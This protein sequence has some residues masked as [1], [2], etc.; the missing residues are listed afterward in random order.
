MIRVLILVGISLVCLS[1][2]NESNE[3]IPISVVS[4]EI[5]NELTVSEKIA[6]AHGFANWTDVNKIEFR[7]NVERDGNTSGRSWTW[8]P[9]T[10][11][12]TLVTDQDTLSF[13]RKSVDSL[14]LNADRGF[15]N[16]KFWLFIPFQLVWDDGTTL[17]DPIKTEAPISKKIMNKITLSYNN[18]GG[19]TPGDAYD[20]FYDDDYL[21]K[22]WVFRKGNSDEPSLTTTFENYQDYNGIILA[23]DH[24]KAEGD[25]NLFFSNIKIN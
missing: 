10:D 12:V 15:I 14:S 24:R 6:Q 20:I 5:T 17:S 3:R 22:E 1:C 19:Y 8:N 18:E 11:H 4:T 25:F 7:F 9:K 23:T 13:N 2:K 21:I 16:D